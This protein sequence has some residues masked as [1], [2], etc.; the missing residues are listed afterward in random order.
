[1]ATTIKLKNGTGAPSAGALVV[2]EP[3]LDLTNKRL[4]TEDS[5]GTV[6]EVGTNP[7]SVT[8][9]D[10]TATGTAIFAGLT[11]TADVLFGDNDKAIFGAGS[12][13]SIYSDGTN[14]IVEGQNADSEVLLLS[15]DRVIIGSKAWGESFAIFNDDGESS[16]YFDGTKRLATTNTGVDVTGTVTVD[17]LTVDGTSTLQNVTVDVDGT[18]GGNYRTIGFS[19]N[20]NGSTRIFGTTDDSDSLYIAAGTGRGIDFWVNGSSSTVLKVDSSGNVGVN[21]TSLSKRLSVGVPLSDTDGLALV[22]SGDPKGGILLSPTTGEVRMGAINSSGTYFPTFYSNNSEAMRITSAG[23]VG[24]GESAPQKMLHIT[25]ND[26]DGVIVLDANGTTTDHQICFSKDYGTGGT[27]GGNYW[28]IGVDGSE[29]KLVFAYDPNSQA[30]LSADAK[31]VIDSSGNVGIG[32]SS[33]AYPFQ[34]GEGTGQ[35]SLGNATGGNSSSRLK[36]LSSNTQKNWQISTND[37]ISGALEFTQTTAGGGTTFATSPAMLIDNSGRF[38]VGTTTQ[39]ISSTQSGEINSVGQTGFAFVQ[40]STTAPNF[41]ITCLNQATGGT[42]SQI[43]FL[44]GSGGGAERGSI[45]TN[46]TSTAYN[47]TSDYRLKENVID[48][49]GAADR[50]QQLAP[51]RFNFIADADK[52]VDGFLAHEVAD[53]VP[54]AISGEKD[55]VDADGNPE[56]QGIDQSKLVPL[57]TAALQEALTKIDALETRIVALEA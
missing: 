11:T 51:K 8:T 6:I 1:M 14:L 27:T 42:R 7:T 46:G 24:I 20:T 12:D 4:Y 30:S 36:F 56:Y 18:Y 5:G 21:V 32:T 34:V 38:F 35:M 43:R 17:G 52:T 41:A 23:F 45:T 10:I 2:A 39:T 48:L 47:T 19:G 50:V 9:G 15:D 54:E 31:V 29:N 57:L 53:I 37:N 16:L 33:P 3:A 22:Y 13:G 25:R 49:T 55:A 40:S 26:S 44:D 28:G